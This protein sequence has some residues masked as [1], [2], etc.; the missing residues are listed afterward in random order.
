MKDT[1]GQIFKFH[2]FGES[3]GPALGCVIEG[4]P[5]GLSFDLQ[6]LE[7]NLQRR[8]PGQNNLVSAR[9]EEDK[10]EILSGVFAGKTLGTPIAILIRNQDQRSKDYEQLPNRRGHATDVWQQKFGHSDPRGGGRASGRETVAR[11]IAGSVAEM[12]IKKLSP[13]TKILSW[14]SQVGPLSETIPL[15]DWPKLTREQIDQSP[16]RTPKKNNEAEAMVLKAKEEGNS[17]GG[18]AQLAILQPPKNL[19]QPV[20]HKLKAD[21]AAALM[22][23]GAVTA[24]ELG[25]GAKAAT[26]EGLDFHV[27]QSEEVYGG[28]RGGISTGEPIHFK[29]SVKPTSSILDVAKKGRHDPFLLPRMIPVIEAMAACVIADHLLWSRLDRIE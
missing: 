13:E 12:L 1:F 3:H 23:I 5:A 28:I 14:T 7:K 6:L 26:Q 19:G 29:I 22:S 16:L 9:D 21:F 17:L 24:V 25:A 15:Q 4:C 8:R 10:P 18:E 27:E 11:V 20:F 2:S